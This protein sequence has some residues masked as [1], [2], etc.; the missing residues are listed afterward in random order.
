MCSV[1]R[2][3]VGTASAVLGTARQIGQALSVAIAT[4]VMAVIIGRHD[5]MPADYPNLLTSIRT[6]FAILTAIAVFGVF[7]SLS[8]GS[9]QAADGDDSVTISEESPSSTV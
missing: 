3:N 5:I 4:L 6:S 1:R 2:R 9:G 7:A 8:R